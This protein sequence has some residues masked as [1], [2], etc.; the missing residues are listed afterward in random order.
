MKEYKTRSSSFAGKKSIFYA[1]SKV[2]T[3][4]MWNWKETFVTQEL[5]S[6]P[7][8]SE[9]SL[10]CSLHRRM[11]CE[12]WLRDALASLPSCTLGQMAIPL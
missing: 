5:S 10:D 12:E 1:D 7:L 11:L 3:R 6:P 2:D 9:S 8:N 4:R